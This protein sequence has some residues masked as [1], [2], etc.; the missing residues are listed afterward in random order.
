AKGLIWILAFN[1]LADHLFH[2]LAGCPFTVY[3]RDPACEEELQLKH[4][5]WSCNILSLSSPAYRRFMDSN[6]AGHVLQCQR[7]KMLD[8]FVKEVPLELD[9]GFYDFLQGL[10]TLFYASY[11]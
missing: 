6:L 2:A 10:P 5:P 11:K 7:L 3:C 1:Y 4:A 9:N 8:S